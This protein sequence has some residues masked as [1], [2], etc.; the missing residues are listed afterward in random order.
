ISLSL[1]SKGN[2][3]FEKKNNPEDFLESSISFHLF[4]SWGGTIAA[5]PEVF[6]KLN[7]LEISLAEIEDSEELINSPLL[8]KFISISKKYLA[9]QYYLDFSLFG[10]YESNQDFSI[11]QY[12]YGVDLGIDCKL[13]KN[14][15][16]NIFD[17]PIAAIRWL[18][19]YDEELNPMGASFPTF[20]ISLE[21]VNPIQFE[22]REV[23]D[24]SGNYSRL[25]GEV[26]FKTPLS[27]SSYFEADLK[28][29]KEINPPAKI[30]DARLNECMYLKAAV[31]TVEGIFISY[32]NGKLPFDLID[33]KI[34]Q[35]GFKYNF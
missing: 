13:W 15:F 14:E 34:Y 10:N 12:S 4:K 1:R 5:T 33:N 3:A 17:Y 29:Y 28:Y 11:K 21:Q 2:I 26:L 27:S 7:E 22:S 25:S 18:S 6:M 23:L 35:L 32:A 16:F 20:V 8:N 24:E 9:D 30:K 31:T 19:G